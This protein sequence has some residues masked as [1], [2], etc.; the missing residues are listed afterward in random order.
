MC[1]LFKFD[2]VTGS[3]FTKIHHKKKTHLF[4]IKDFMIKNYELNDH[5]F[6]VVCEIGHK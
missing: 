5:R 2:S 4:R 6:N 3:V 1:A